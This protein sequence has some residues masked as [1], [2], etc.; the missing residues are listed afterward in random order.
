MNQR[1][2]RNSEVTH[3]DKQTK[4]FDGVTSLAITFKDGTESRPTH[5]EAVFDWD[6]AL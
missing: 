4:N 2:E 1:V 5:A 6:F 3:T